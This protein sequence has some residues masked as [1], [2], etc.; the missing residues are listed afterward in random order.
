MYIDFQD[1]TSHITTETKTVLEK[2]I[3]YTSR[4]ENIATN[5]ELSIS[6]VDNKTIKTLN[7]TYR[8]LNEI[9]DVLSF[10]M[11]DDNPDVLTKQ[12]DI[13]MAIG[14]IVVSVDR[15]RE[16]ANEYNHSLMRELGFLTIHG[17]LHLLGYDHEEKTDEQIM[18]AKQKMILDAFK[19]ER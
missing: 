10:G 16:Q 13:P 5:T 6:F 3:H 4:M 7:N 15:A 14:D 9:T 1:Q 11:H 19:I 18:F 17:F 12:S 2:L 8:G